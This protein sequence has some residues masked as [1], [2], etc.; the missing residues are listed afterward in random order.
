MAGPLPRHLC[1]KGPNTGRLLSPSRLGEKGTRRGPWPDDYV[2]LLLLREI[3]ERRRREEPPCTVHHLS[4]LPGMPT[5]RDQRIRR[6]VEQLCAL[7]YAAKVNVGD[8]T[9]YEITTPGVDWWL[10][11]QPSFPLFHSLRKRDATP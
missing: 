6:L 5:Q 11:F 4:T 10:K 2:I 8:L 1:T 3:F 7:G 9:G